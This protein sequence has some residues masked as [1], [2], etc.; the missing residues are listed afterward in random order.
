MGS[1]KAPKQ[2]VFTPTE[3][4]AM[5]LALAGAF[6][7][8]KELGLPRRGLE[9]ALRRRLFDIASEGITDPEMMRNE[10]L[11]RMNVDRVAT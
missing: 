8:V 4:R 9:G 1:L 6:A 3:L 5:D 7:T 2:Q 11:K 10:L